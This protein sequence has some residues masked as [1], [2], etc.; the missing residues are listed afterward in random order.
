MVDRVKP[1]E[2]V[3][4]QTVGRRV[5]DVEFATDDGQE[6]GN[7][8]LR[9]PEL[10]AGSRLRQDPRSDLSFAAGIL[11]YGLTGRNP[12]ILQ[13]AEGRLPHQRSAAL[14]TLKSAVGARLPRLLSLF[15]D[16][17]APR[18]TDRFTTA[19]TMLAGLDRVMEPRPLD[20]GTPEDDLNVIR[21]VMNTE[22]TRR[23]SDRAK[24]LSDAP[25]VGSLEQ[26]RERARR[27]RRH[28]LAFVYD[29]TQ[30]KRGKLGYCLGYFL[31]NRKT[32]ETIHAAFVVALVKLSQ[33]VAVTDILNEKSMESARW[34]IFD[35]DLQAKQQAVIYA[36]AQEGEKIAC[37]LAARYGS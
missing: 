34:V 19:D 8:F 10:S 9:L 25:P 23:R 21:E 18:I 29:P 7:R 30:P 12:N 33:V 17:F 14:A 35:P 3:A 28:I 26:A 37:E 27:E 24:R 5:P 6:I 15:D 16:A 1:T 20:S 36:N 31:E 13:D 2:R 32:R 4:P 11:F 22:A